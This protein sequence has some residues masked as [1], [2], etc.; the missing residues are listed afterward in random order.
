M[1]NIDSQDIENK[2]RKKVHFDNTI[3]ILHDKTSFC[4]SLIDIELNNSVDEERS[5]ET[6]NI[7]T[8]KFIKKVRICINIALIIFIFLLIAVLLSIL[9]F[10]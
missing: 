9:I 4:S 7:N 8:N 2:K 6:E 10:I 1:Y 3:N 5:I